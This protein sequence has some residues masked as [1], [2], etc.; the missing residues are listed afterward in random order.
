MSHLVVVPYFAGALFFWP[1]CRLLNCATAPV[2][3]RLRRNFLVTLIALASL[4]IVVKS[5]G[6]DELWRR[7]P[8]PLI[9][10]VSLWFS[11]A[12]WVEKDEA[13]L[14]FLQKPHGA[15]AAGVVFVAV[16]MMYFIGGFMKVDIML[17]EARTTATVTGIRS[18]GV[19]KYRY[20][21]AGHAYTGG[22]DPGNPPY[23]IGSTYEIRYSS[24]HPYFSTAQ[25]PSIFFGQMLVACLFMG[26]AT[27]FM[28][29]AQKPAPKAQP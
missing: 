12:A 8:F 14:S 27:L 17:H 13:K 28:R 23:P 26:G 29:S 22:G 15:A 16:C 5:I 1:I 4:A 10:C 21:V 9:N 19:L 18:H 6:D 20:E 3:Q 11:T 7:M 24:A 2:L 25:D